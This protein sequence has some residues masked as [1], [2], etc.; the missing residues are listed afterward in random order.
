MDI[1]FKHIIEKSIKVSLQVI[2]V[3]VLSYHFLFE[4]LKSHRLFAGLEERAKI[5]DIGWSK[6]QMDRFRRSWEREGT[7]SISRHTTFDK[8]TKDPEKIT[9]SIELLADSVH[10]N[11]TKYYLMFRAV[12]IIVRFEDFTTDTRAKAVPI[13][14]SEHWFN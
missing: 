8:D 3:S 6:L 14:T 13:W 5:L 4:H 11:L 9:S 2:N 7:K 1:V 10:I 12:M